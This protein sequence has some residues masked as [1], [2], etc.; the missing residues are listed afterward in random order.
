MCH[1]GTGANATTLLIDKPSLLNLCNLVTP[2][3]DELQERS[4]A[5]KVNEIEA[6]DESGAVTYPGSASFF[7]AP[8][9]NKQALNTHPNGKCS[10]HRIQRRTQ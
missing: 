2:K 6:P 9:L 8:W 10:S 7:A 4:N 5:N 1:S 3:I